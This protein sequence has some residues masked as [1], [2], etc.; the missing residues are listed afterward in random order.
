MSTV[1]RPCESIASPTPLLL[2]FELGERTCK[3][4]FSTASG[5]AT[6][7]ALG[8]P[9]CGIAKRSREHVGEHL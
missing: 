7:S 9:R 3:L 6:Y 5:A 8:R 2:A 4:G 1:T